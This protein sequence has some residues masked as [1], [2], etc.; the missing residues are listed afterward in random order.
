MLK[1]F[2]YH[3]NPWR[4][5]YFCLDSDKPFVIE[6][7]SGIFWGY[8]TLKEAMLSKRHEENIFEFNEGGWHEVYF[9]TV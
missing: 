3:Y 8:S 9:V 6:L 2:G 7:K 4:K 5:K 1:F